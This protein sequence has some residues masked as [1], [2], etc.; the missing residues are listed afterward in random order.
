MK[1]ENNEKPVKRLAHNGDS[2]AGGAFAPLL[3]GE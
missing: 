3:A 2:G 1:G